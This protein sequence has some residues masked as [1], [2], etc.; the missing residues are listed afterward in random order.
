MTKRKWIMIGTIGF[1][2]CLSATAMAVEE[3]AGNAPAE[4]P[5]VVEIPISEPEPAE[6][7]A[8]EPASAADQTAEAREAAGEELPA[9]MGIPL[10]GEGIAPDL[11]LIGESP[12]LKGEIPVK[13]T[14]GVDDVIMIDVRRHPEFSGTYGINSEGKIQYKYVGDIFV[15][16]MTKTEIK[17]KLT[18][19]LSSYLVDPAVEVTIVEYRSK[20]FYVIG[21]VGRPGKYYM[22]ADEIPIREAVVQAGLPLLS[23]SAGK[24]KLITPDEKGKPKT[25]KINLDKILYKGDLRQ[26][27]MMKPG[28][29]L[30][31]PATL[32]TKFM[33]K[34]APVAQPV[35]AAAGAESSFYRLGTGDRYRQ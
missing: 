20:V 26:N 13:Y 9:V 18:K 25:I 10:P 19:I 35:Q 30:Y 16:S 27:T 8:S 2:L 4:K 5:A 12:A 24:S 11:S 3:E 7:V 1:L 33:R 34:I 17:D 31:V 14:L 32:V 29:V 21:E 28:D 23:A 6:P 15:S 22:W